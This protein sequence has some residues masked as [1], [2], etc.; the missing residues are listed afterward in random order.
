MTYKIFVP[1][2]G[3]D[4]ALRALTHAIKL[5]QRM[6]DSRIVVAHAH[7][8]PVIYGEIAVYVPLATME[9]M[10]RAHS[11]S[12]LEAADALLAKAG[13]PYD[14]EILTGPIAQVLAE[15]A[16]TLGCDTI[17]MGT[18]GSTAIGNML[19]G[20]IATKIVHLSKIPVTLVR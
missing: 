15:R 7:E 3:S 9:T 1:I 18:H 14:K 10:Q 19:M 20:S 8:E 12:V 11:E 13:V 5:A 6:G 2:D 16:A 17:V 4:A